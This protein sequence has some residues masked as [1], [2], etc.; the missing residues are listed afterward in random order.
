M[1]MISRAK[2][3]EKIDRISLSHIKADDLIQFLLN[4]LPKT[5]FNVILTTDV[6]PPQY[7]ANNM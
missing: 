2:D 5:L 1:K 3:N 4:S 7:R 6:V